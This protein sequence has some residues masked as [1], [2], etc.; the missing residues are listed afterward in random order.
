MRR[1]W[2]AGAYLPAAAAQP[3]SV[4]SNVRLDRRL[5][6]RLLPCAL[7]PSLARGVRSAA[8]TNGESPRDLVS[9]EEEAQRSSA[10]VAPRPSKD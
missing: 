9:S 7:S 6:L 2:R 8:L 10:T 4:L 3:R 5:R 1:R